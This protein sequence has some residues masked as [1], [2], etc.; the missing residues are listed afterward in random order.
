MRLFQPPT[1]LVHVA[2][3]ESPG[4][5][6][7]RLRAYVQYYPPGATVCMHH[8]HA[9]TG[10]EAKRMAMAE[11]REKCMSGRGGKS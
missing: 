6:R 5:R 4:V 3:H 11:H 9:A 1:G 8:V 10:A 2:V 7:V